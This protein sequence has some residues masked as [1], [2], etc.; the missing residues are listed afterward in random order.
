MTNDDQLPFVLEGLT[1]LA[2]RALPPFL[3]SN[4]ELLSVGWGGGGV[5]LENHEKKKP[6]INSVG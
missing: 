6:K 3:S 2:K 5:K 1:S 4:N